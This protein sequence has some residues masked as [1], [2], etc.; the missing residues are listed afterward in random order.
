MLSGA[1]ADGKSQYGGIP[2]DRAIVAAAQEL[3]E[4]VKSSIDLERGSVLRRGFGE[5]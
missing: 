5:R 1:S 4:L 2:V 3:G